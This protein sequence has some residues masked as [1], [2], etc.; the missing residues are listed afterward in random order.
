MKPSL[1]E[2]RQQLKAQKIAPSHQ[3]LKVLEYL[4]LNQCH[5]TAD[6]IFTSLQKEISTLS[7]TTVYNTLR[8]LTEAGLVRVVAIEDKEAR[9]DIL[10]EDH[11]HFKCESCGDI[12]N[13]KI[14]MGALVSGDLAHFRIQDKNVYFKGVCP[15][16]LA[17]QNKT[18]KGEKS[19]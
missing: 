1:E 3:R 8:V 9:Y 16:C 7:K 2:L 15:R 6:Q 4:A 18:E 11:G 17:A 14:D 19:I 13:F 5:P 12:Y 10:T